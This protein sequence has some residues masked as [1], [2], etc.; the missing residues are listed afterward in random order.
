M[1]VLKSV[2]A[3]SNRERTDG[4]GRKIENEKEAVPPQK[5]WDRKNGKSRKSLGTFLIAYMLW[6]W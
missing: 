6:N 4:E 5:L 3:F 2:A 1:V